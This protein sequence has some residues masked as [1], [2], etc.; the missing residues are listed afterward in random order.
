MTNMPIKNLT[1]SAHGKR[2]PPFAVEFISDDEL[3]IGPSQSEAAAIAT[4]GVPD[5]DVATRLIARVGNVLG[6]KSASAQ[7]TQAEANQ[8]N[9]ERF[10]DAGV[11]MHGLEPEDSMEGMTAAMLVAVQDAVVHLLADATT[12]AKE[13]DNRARC[14]G[15]ADRLIS[16]FV[17]LADLRTRLRGGGTTQRVTVEHV[18]VAAGGQAVIGAVASPGGTGGRSTTSDDQPHA[19]T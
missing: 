2:P 7:M 4:T 5:V 1:T 15:S 18:T 9:Q 12:G 10:N 19:Q 14:A 3:K 6:A 11:K 8:H 17:R 16:A 13:Y